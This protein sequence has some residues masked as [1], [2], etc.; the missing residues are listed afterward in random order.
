MGKIKRDWIDGDIAVSLLS[1]LQ[2]SFLRNVVL[3]ADDVGTFIGKCKNNELS[4]VEVVFL[5][6]IITNLSFDATKELGIDWVSTDGSLENIREQ[7]KK[8][9][10]FA[11][12]KLE[13]LTY[14][15]IVEHINSFPFEYIMK[16]LAK[17]ACNEVT[18]NDKRLDALFGLLRGLACLESLLILLQQFDV[19]SDAPIVDSTRLYCRWCWGVAEKFV[20]GY[21]EL[22]HPVFP[23]IAVLDTLCQRSGV[24][25]HQ[26]F[27]AICK[28]VMA[29]DTAD[30]KTDDEKTIRLFVESKYSEEAIEALLKS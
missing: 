5:S 19:V 4:F 3:V 22:F 16:R 18:D 11:H 14:E 23:Y 13:E 30:L 28:D 6:S 12:D 26:L 27:N 25:F 1:K 21:P 10:S 17:L 15:E 7:C 29:K 9:K 8:I 20:L 2:D 24:T